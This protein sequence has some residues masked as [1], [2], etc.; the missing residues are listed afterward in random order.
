MSLCASVFD[1]SD[2]IRHQT[3]CCLLEHRRIILYLAFVY[4]PYVSSVNGDLYA[5]VPRVNEAIILLKVQS[6]LHAMEL[7]KK[8]LT[9]LSLYSGCLQSLHSLARI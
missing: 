7:S 4:Q 1:N 2:A 3:P 8:Q 9:F 5:G 6:L